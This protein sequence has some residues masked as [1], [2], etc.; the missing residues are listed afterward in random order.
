MKKYGLHVKDGRMINTRPN[1]EMGITKIARKKK[2]I[3]RAK[4]VSM[5]TEAITIAELKEKIKGL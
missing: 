3:D 4:K 5:I 1:C 2:S